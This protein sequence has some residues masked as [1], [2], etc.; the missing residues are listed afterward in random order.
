VLFEELELLEELR[1]DTV[2][3]VYR[4]QLDL[5]F[6]IF[7]RDGLAQLLGLLHAV[8]ALT[9]LQCRLEEVLLLDQRKHE[10]VIQQALQ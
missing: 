5:A 1:M 10:N 8:N 3:L 4:L 6:Q 9:L 7:I 2:N